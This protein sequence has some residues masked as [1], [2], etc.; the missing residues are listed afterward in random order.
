MAHTGGNSLKVISL[1]ST[2]IPCHTKLR[3]EFVPAENDKTYTVSFWAKIDSNQGQSR[4]VDISIQSPDEEWPG[5]YTETIILD[6]LEWKEYKHS[7]V[8]EYKNWLEEVRVGLCIA[9]SDVDFW[10]DD[11]KFFEDKE[12]EVEKAVSVINK[13]I[14]SWAETKF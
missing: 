7:F 3:H 12:I 13:H 4:K 11:F 5:F 10:I 9:Q 6:S 1:V 14:I 8:L 2:G